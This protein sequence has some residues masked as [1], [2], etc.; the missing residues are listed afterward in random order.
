M[1]SLIALVISAL[2]SAACCAHDTWVQTNTNVVRTGDL[3]H[4]DLMLGNP[5]NGHR[6][7]KLASQISLEPCTLEVITPQ[8]KAYDVKP[9]LIDTGYAPKEGFWT[10]RYTTDTPGI[11]TVAHTLDTLHRTTRAIKSGKTYFVASKILDDV[12]EVNPGFEKPLGHA[13]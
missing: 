3:V 8:G 9:K 2:L 13:R 1:R 5:G 10:C 7:F 4:V 11:Y 12:S 6:D